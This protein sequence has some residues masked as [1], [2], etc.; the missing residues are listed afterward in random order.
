MWSDPIADMLTR[1]RNAYR[2]SKIEVAMPYSKLKEAIAHV[3]Q[4][5]KFIGEIK[6]T[7]KDKKKT[8]SCYLLYK[9]GKPA[10]SA[11]K[12]PIEHIKRISKA[13]QRVYKK[14]SEIRP[15]LNGYGVSIVSTNKGIMA[16][17]EAKKKNLGGEVIAEV[18]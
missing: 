9:N 3:L 8:L 17:M 2:A 5:N 14:A 16:G 7:E 1:I 10:D 18:W 11:G 6:V 13:G 4:K 15:I 12:A